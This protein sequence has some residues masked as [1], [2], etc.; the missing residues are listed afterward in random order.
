M[1]AHPAV[2]ST[3]LATTDASQGAPRNA[4]NRPPKQVT[5]SIF[6]AT[7]EFIEDLWAVFGTKDTL[8]P[9][10]VYHG[11]MIKIT[12]ADI[13]AMER[14]LMGYKKFILKHEKHLLLGELDKI[15][16]TEA[17]EYNQKVFLPVV[18]IY[19]QGQPDVK[20]GIVCH[21]L[22]IAH[23]MHPQSG[24]GQALKNRQL[25]GSAK[26]T[27]T[28]AFNFGDIFSAVGT[29]SALNKGIVP[30]SKPPP[31][32]KNARKKKGRITVDEKSK[33]GAF[34]SSIMARV[35]ET[36]QDKDPGTAFQS[37]GGVLSELVGGM[38]QGLA[39]GEMDSGKLMDVMQG[40]FASVRPTFSTD[41][42]KED[43]NTEIKE[44]ADNAKASS[45]TK[46][47]TSTKP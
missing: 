1:D 22:A 35:E 12:V 29:I 27:E 18:S 9:L 3:P 21:L 26:A 38:Q 8:S 44:D 15:A 43:P 42:P 24:F 36:V 19:K 17:I 46:A 2:S 11:L 47:E 20:E 10:F 7:L 37:I 25:K 30:G 23:L 14:T 34:M 16:E 45:E 33:E 41:T 40:V 6:N 32:S 4:A 13:K 28:P 5:R 31:Q 39:S